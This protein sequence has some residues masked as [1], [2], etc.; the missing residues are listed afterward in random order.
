MMVLAPSSGEM[1]RTA[2]GDA[3]APSANDVARIVL[4]EARGDETGMQAVRGDAGAVE[5]PRQFAREQDVAELRRAIDAESRAVALLALQIVEIELGRECASDA[6]ETMRA[7][8][9]AFSRS[10]RTLVTTK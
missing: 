1:R 7:P 4:A 6:V 10:S 3:Q 8:G 5:P 9:V 2:Y